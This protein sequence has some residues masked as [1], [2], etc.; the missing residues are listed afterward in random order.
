MEIFVLRSYCTL[1]TLEERI[2]DLKKTG[3]VIE[4][5]RATLKKGQEDYKSA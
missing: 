1:D 3:P 4:K 2:A 5:V